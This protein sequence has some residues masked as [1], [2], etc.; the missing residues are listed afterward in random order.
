MLRELT[1]FLLSVDVLDNPFKKVH[2]VQLNE[3][4]IGFTYCVSITYG[5]HI[6]GSAC[7][8]LS[9]HGK[10]KDLANFLR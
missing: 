9:R 5:D 8:S 6:S 2:L 10:S 3:A 1:F 4:Y 7:A